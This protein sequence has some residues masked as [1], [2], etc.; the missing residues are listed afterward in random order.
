MDSSSIAS[1]IRIFIDYFKVRITY[2]AATGY[3]DIVNGVAAANIGKV[4]GV[5]TANIGKVNGVD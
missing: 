3:G 5:T 1:G 2:T 4:N